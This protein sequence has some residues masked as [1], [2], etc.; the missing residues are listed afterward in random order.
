MRFVPVWLISLIVTAT[1]A[2][3]Q[4]KGDACYPNY[5]SCMERGSSRPMSA[6][7]SCSQMW[8]QTANKCYDGTPA[9]VVS[10]IAPA[11]A[12]DR[13]R[14]KNRAPSAEDRPA[15]ASI[16]R[17]QPAP[18]KLEDTPIQTPPVFTQPV[19]GADNQ[20]P[21]ITYQP[22]PYVQQQPS[23]TYQP[24]PSAPY[25]QPTAPA[26]QPAPYQQAAP[27]YPQ[28]P[29]PYSQQGVPYQPQAAP[30]PQYSQ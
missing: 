8:E 17:P 29:A 9:G 10:K 18:A 21:D 24:S 3:A 27:Y 28:Q 11:K 5:V 26:S 15:A 25:Q 22:Q 12:D 30:Y 16:E 7:D 23:V 13:Q 4:G 19:A 2:W 20:Q 6:Y 14:P 1:G